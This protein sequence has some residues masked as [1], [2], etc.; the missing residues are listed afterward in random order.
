MQTQFLA[1]PGGRI[2]YDDTGPGGPLV[3]LVP[4]LGDSRRSYRFLQPR[5]AEAGYR[6]VSVDLR[7]LGESTA[8]W[9]DYTQTAI[10]LDLVDL[11]KHL[12]AGPAVLVGNSYAAGAI[13]W[14]A[15][16]APTLVAGIVPVGGFLRKPEMTSAGRVF[17]LTA[18]RSATVW[19]NFYRYAHRG[20][21][22]ADL[23]VYR[24]GLAAMLRQPARRQALCAMLRSPA[25]EAQR[26]ACAINCPALV[27]MGSK[28]PYFPDPAAEAGWQ[29]ALLD[30]PAHL[31]GGAGHYPQSEVPDR[32]AALLLPFLDRALG[33]PSRPTGGAGLRP[34]THPAPEGQSGKP[35]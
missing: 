28:D 8:E 19:T 9:R 27:V 29:A 4:A 18:A 21:K 25:L 31:I 3:V 33:H 10:G 14:A 34:G 24:A 23:A 20:A 30:C 7:G 16:Q 5:L 13:V 22:P 2:A 6:A 15:A 1:I 32:M 17:M 35:E 11:L 12:D 26:W